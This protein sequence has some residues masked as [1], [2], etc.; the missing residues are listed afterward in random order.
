M[1]VE[2]KSVAPVAKVHKMQLL[3]Y[4][5][6]TDKRVGL[7]LNFNECLIKDG[8]H[9][10]VNNLQRDLCVFASLR[11]IRPLWA[12]RCEIQR[13]G[14]CY[15]EGRLVRYKCPNQQRKRVRMVI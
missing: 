11:E 9:R 4:L 10:I 2:V 1:I 13:L 3:T 8:I 14:G 15:I 6:L 5:R 12:S 7:L